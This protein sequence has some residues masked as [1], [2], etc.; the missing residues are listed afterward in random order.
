LTYLQ[1]G[2]SL[3]IL[4]LIVG[5]YRRSRRILTATTIVFTLWSWQPVSA[6]L[7]ASLERRY[8]ARDFPEGDA[9]AIV[10]LTGGVYKHHAGM[11]EDLPQSDQYIRAAYASWLYRN[12]KPLPIVASGGL[13]NGVVLG[14]VMRRVLEERGVPASMIWVEGRSRS[15]YENAVYSAELLRAKSIRRIVLVTEAYHMPRAE[16][17]FR[18]QGLTVVPAPCAFRHKEFTGELEQFVPSPQAMQRNELAL[19]E[20]MGLIWYRLRGR[21]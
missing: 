7:M 3:F 5:I 10:A 6:L 15:T 4:A 14:E 2:I 19:H 9:E 12:W 18:R 1:P 16:L 21:A 8:P 11:P 17:A 13:A 20:W